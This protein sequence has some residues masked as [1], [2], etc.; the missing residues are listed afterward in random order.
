MKIQWEE[1]PDHA[2]VLGKNQKVG[3]YAEFASELRKNP[4]RWAVLPTN[5]DRTLKGAMATAQNI[6]RGKVRGF[7]AG[8]YEV[9]VDKT[10]IYV[11]FKGEVEFTGPVDDEDDDEPESEESV[12]GEMDLA[13]LAP[14]VRTWAKQKGIDVP[15]RGRLPRKLMKQWSEETGVELPVRLIQ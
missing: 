9:A 1:P 2:H 4:D 13:K 14:R 5:E 8:E 11:M 12:A 15:D 7:K 10:R 3:K 6:R